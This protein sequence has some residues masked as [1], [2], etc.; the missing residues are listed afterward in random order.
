MPTQSVGTS[1]V[2]ATAGSP[3]VCHLEKRALPDKPAAAPRRQSSG[4]PSCSPVPPKPEQSQ[5][6]ATI[7]LKNHP[8]RFPRS[9][10]EDISEWA[11]A[12]LRVSEKLAYG[13][14]SGLL[15][16]E[17]LLVPTLRVGTP[18]T[19]APRPESPQSGGTPMPTQGV[20]T[21]DVG[22]ATGLPAVYRLRK[23]PLPNKPAAAPRRQSS[24]TPSCSPVSPKP[25][26]SQRKATIGLK[27]HSTQFPRSSLE[28][29]S[30]WTPA[31]LRVSEKLAYGYAT[32]LLRG[33]RLL[34]PTLRVGA[35]STDAP[36]P[37]SPQ[38]GGT[39][40]PTQS[41]G[42]SDVGATAGLPAVG[43]LEN[44]ELPDKPPVAPSRFMRG[45]MVTFIVALACFC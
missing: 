20:G 42:T 2:G 16:G 6:K 30:E 5:R 36:R 34:V 9:S 26:Q 15:R 14:A 35:P 41:V 31:L 29:I 22:A 19:D 28:D 12:L 33:E 37:E 32:R 18:A 27:N 40:I 3:A 24:G 45:H 8:T 10:L 11:P 21:S 13:Y 44:R 17:R 39:P 4:T 38:S 7:G 1:D 43:R 23:R 25:E